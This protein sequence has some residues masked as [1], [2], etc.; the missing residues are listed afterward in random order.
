MPEARLTASVEAASL[1]R[2]AT[3]SGDFAAVLRKGDPERGS[4]III[5]RS[6]GQYVATL[7][8]LLGTDGAYRWERSG[9]AKS[10]SEPELAEFLEKRICVDPDLWL[11]ELDI[12]QAERFIAE[13]TGAA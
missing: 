8:R 10:E 7:E 11:V 2:R 4:L 12:A 9:P 13:T 3:S 5:V 1:V 6:R